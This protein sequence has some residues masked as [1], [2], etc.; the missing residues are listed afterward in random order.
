MAH[1]H[2]EYASIFRWA[3]YFIGL[4]I[5]S[6]GIVLTIKANVGCAPWDVLHIGLYRNFGLTIGTWSIIVGLVVLT[7]SA[8]L[9]KQL[10]RIGAFLNMIFVGI[11]IDLYMMIPYLQV[12]NTLIGKFVMLLVGIVITGYGMGIYISANIGA[13][14]RDSLMLALTELT[15]WK[16]QYIRIAMEAFVLFI[17]WI[18]GG[19]VSIGTLIFCIMIGSVAGVALP[20]CQR[21]AEWI[22]VR[23]VDI[24]THGL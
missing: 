24:E 21:M 7:I 20:Q 3:I 2:R 14:P 15:G 5:M 4:L 18:L 13:G 10:L 6:F 19:P 22:L 11:F 23:R 8:L 12:P 16:V 17:G 9:L 1:S